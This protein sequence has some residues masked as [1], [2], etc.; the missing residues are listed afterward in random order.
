MCF[1]D[2]TNGVFVNDFKIKEQ[3]LE[4]GDVVQFGGAAD[5]PV[6]TRFGG[7]GSHIRCANGPP[8][9]AFVLPPLNC[10]L[11]IKMVAVNY[12]QFPR[13]EHKY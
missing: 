8:Y 11:G 10:H 13:Q 12:T 5:I 1:Q 6:G 3:H 4:H 7:T 2:S 9:L